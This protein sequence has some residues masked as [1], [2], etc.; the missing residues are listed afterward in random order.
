MIMIVCFYW[1]VEN[2]FLKDSSL[3]SKVQQ[4]TKKVKVTIFGRAAFSY[5]AVQ[6][7]F[8]ILTSPGHWASL[9]N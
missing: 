4:I 7:P 6:L 3:S 5:S 2:T 1:H 9:G 8:D